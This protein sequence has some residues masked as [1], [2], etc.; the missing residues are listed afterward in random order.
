MKVRF[1]SAIA[2]P[3]QQTDKVIAINSCC[4]MEMDDIVSPL[5]DQLIK[6]PARIYTLNGLLGLIIET[7]RNELASLARSFYIYVCA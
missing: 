4:E 2:S 6:G 1:F 7:T 3:P 5:S